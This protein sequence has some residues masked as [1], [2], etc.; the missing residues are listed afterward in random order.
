MNILYRLGLRI[1]LSWARRVSAIACLCP[2]VS[3]GPLPWPVSWTPS[4]HKVSGCSLDM[5]GA[6]KLIFSWQFVV[7]CLSTDHN[8]ITICQ[9]LNNIQICLSSFRGGRNRALK[10]RIDFKFTFKKMFSTRLQDQTVESR[11]PDCARH[12]AASTQK[13]GAKPMHHC[14]KTAREC[15]PT[16]SMASRRTEKKSFQYSKVTFHVGQLQMLETLLCK[17]PWIHYSFSSEHTWLSSRPMNHIYCLPL[18]PN[19]IPSFISRNPSKTSQNNIIF[20]CNIFMKLAGPCV[21]LAFIKGQA[22]L[23]R[24][25]K[26]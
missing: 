8:S 21:L 22:M 16:L 12:L 18:S 11:F 25:E 9:I 4:S 10:M 14:V 15:R 1:E 13:P 7:C 19:R 3:A 17:S 26:G 6:G 20:A 24:R 23:N 5:G 2:Q